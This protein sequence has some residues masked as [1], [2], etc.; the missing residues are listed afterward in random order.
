M[1]FDERRSRLSFI[2]AFMH[3]K[4]SFTCFF[5]VFTAFSLKAEETLESYSLDDLL[6]SAL[7][8]NQEIDIAGLKVTQADIALNRAFYQFFPDLN[9]ELGNAN[10]RGLFI[11]PSTN[12][13]TREFVYGTHAEVNT[14]VVLFRGFYQQR[15]YTMNRRM[16]EAASW[17]ERIE[18]QRLF[19]KIVLDFY[20]ISLLK[21]DILQRE[22]YLNELEDLNRLVSS[23]IQTGLTHP[24]EL[25][26]IRAEFADVELQILE[27]Q[28]EI[29]ELTESLSYFTGI[30]PLTPDLLE[31]ADD[32][33]L[34]TEE[35]AAPNPVLAYHAA[36][37][38]VAEA[39]IHMSRAAGMPKLSLEGAA[40]TRTS[41]L[42]EEAFG[43][44]LSD[45]NYQYFGVK[46]NIPVFNRFHYRSNIEKAKASLEISKL[47]NQ[48][49]ARDFA[50][51]IEKIRRNIQLLEARLTTLEKRESAYREQ[52][53]Y[54]I[55]QFRNGL[56]DV[57]EINHFSRLLNETGTKSLKTQIEILSAQLDLALLLGNSI[58]E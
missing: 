54:K 45:N 1:R 6:R 24:R 5:I 8:N 29:D 49:V 2:P 28:L 51:E 55:E 37:I 57:L 47:E 13:L 31:E 56:V 50:L 12:V 43:S 25:S 48:I 18:Q 23:R 21:K 17:I 26:L 58:V 40:G 34:Q 11:D 52:L 33:E 16:L 30:F 10:N 19:R 32:K 38:E 7:E 39:R 3:A 22:A 9:V 44:Q 41:S 15:N 36:L 20:S 14:E 46:L 42:S 53:E 35:S 4:W 27:N